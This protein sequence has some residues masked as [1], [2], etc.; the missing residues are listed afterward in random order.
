MFL[1]NSNNRTGLR[2]LLIFIGFFSLFSCNGRQ[3][4]S[5]FQLLDGDEKQVSD[6]QGR[7]L[8]VNFWAEWCKP[9]LEEV[10]EL[11]ALHRRKEEFNWDLLAFSYE[12]VNNEQLN[13]AITK[14]GIEYP[15]VATM[16]QPVVP[17]ERPSK[18]PAMLIISPD[19]DVLGPLYGKQ[20]LESVVAAINEI[21]QRL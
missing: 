21:K 17:F 14:Y 12:P 2:L 20:D 11:N 4:D 1:H 7:W 9:C 18:L 8:L 13:Q 10:P 15:M 6:Y 3:D 19:G 16:P 5:R